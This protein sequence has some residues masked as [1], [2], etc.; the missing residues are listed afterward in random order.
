M[1][2][3]SLALVIASAGYTYVGGTNGS[4]ALSYRGDQI[5]VY[6]S[7]PQGP[8]VFHG[9]TA[10]LAAWADSASV[11]SVPKGTTARF[12]YFD[13]WLRDTI[14]VELTRLSGDPDPA[15]QCTA[16]VGRSSRGVVLSPDSARR[17]LALLHGPPPVASALP[18]DPRDAA[19]FDF[20]VEKQA[21][22][23]PQ[24]LS[25]KYP[26]PARVAGISGEVLAQFVVDTLGFVDLST[27]R[28]IKSTGPWFTSAVQ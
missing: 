12:S 16:T 10:A 24:S 26:E 13:D 19:Y 14:L 22:P 20:Q 2:L 3:V 4:L 25:P 8:F 28:V 18:P 1:F 7:T 9:S 6:G 23:T 15:F 27:F 5:W 17:F 11:T 21:R